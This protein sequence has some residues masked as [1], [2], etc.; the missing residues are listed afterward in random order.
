MRRAGNLLTAPPPPGPRTWPYGAAYARPEPWPL[1]VLRALRWPAAGLAALALA[2]V[3][4]CLFAGFRYRQLDEVVLP[5]GT[6]PA[7]LGERPAARA[8]VPAKLARRIASQAPPGV[9]MTIDTV[10]NRL[11]L[12]RGGEVLLAAPCSTGTGGI[13]TDPASGRRWVFETPRGTYR[14]LAKVRKPLWHKPD[15]AFIE[16]GLPVPRDPAQRIDDYSLG[17]YALSLGDGYLIHGTLYQRLLGR[18]V[19]HGCI[20]LGDT[21]LEKIFNSVPL[22]TPVFIY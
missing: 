7:R 4:A 20:R 21:D 1:R 12:K 9:Y 8:A 13:L 22:G 14:V 2:V 16:E 10:A 3:L 19:T 15:W 6:V 5:D 18:S 11:Y 17:S